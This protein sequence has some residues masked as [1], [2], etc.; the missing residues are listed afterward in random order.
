MHRME[1]D[2][3]TS[4]QQ[5]CELIS[6][7]DLIGASQLLA[8]E[9][10]F[11]PVQSNNRNYTPSQ[12]TAVFVRDGFI[13][14]YRG[15]R[16]VFPAALRLLSRYLPEA[17]PFHKNWKMSACHLAYWELC[18]T[19]DHIVPVALG[20]ADAEANWASCSMLTNS[21]KSNWS[22]EQLQWRLHPAGSLI[23]WDGL[24]GWFARQVAG[25]QAVLQDPYSRQRQVTLPR[26]SLRHLTVFP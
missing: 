11:T 23:E 3:A 12:A 21:I 5:A 13:D 7:G 10:P 4:I 19:V 6:A 25:D 1:A 26:A 15:G 14:R 2:R 22:L 17:F 18:P 9:Y 20:G 24:L 16:L 8:N